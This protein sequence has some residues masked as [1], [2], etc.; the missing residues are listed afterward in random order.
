MNTQD[1]SPLGWTQDLM[2]DYVFY[3]K[4]FDNGASLGYS[5]SVC[6]VCMQ[7]IIRVL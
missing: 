1:W 5:H 7:F 4:K 2:F 3:S 6:D